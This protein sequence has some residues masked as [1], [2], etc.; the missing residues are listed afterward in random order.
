MKSE[1]VRPY[2][3]FSSMLFYL[4]I[5]PTPN[6]KDYFLNSLPAYSMYQ[7]LPSIPGRHLQPAVPT[8][9]LKK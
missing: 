8:D 3:T 5:S 4:S 1:N 6:L 2:A 7:Q 9:C